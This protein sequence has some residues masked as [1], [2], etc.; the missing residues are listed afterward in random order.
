MSVISESKKLL[1]ARKRLEQCE[2][3]YESQRL[4]VH[5]A[6]VNSNQEY[7]DVDGFRITH[8]PESTVMIFTQDGLRAELLRRGL[9][10]PAITQVIASSKTEAARDSIIRIT[11]LKSV[12]AP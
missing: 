1:A 5:N 7:I 8:V 3:E 10:E 2:Q 12:S 6:L 9:R 4:V 11:K